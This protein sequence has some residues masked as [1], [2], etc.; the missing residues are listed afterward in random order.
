MSDEITKAANGINN[1]E[2]AENPDLNSLNLEDRSEEHEY[3]EVRED[4]G[5]QDQEST[6]KQR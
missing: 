2:L 1:N 4:Q 5:A 3:Q 6:R